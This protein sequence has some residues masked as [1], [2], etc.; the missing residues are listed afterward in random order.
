[1]RS[2]RNTKKERSMPE[3]KERHLGALYQAFSWWEQ[4]F[5]IKQ[6]S[7]NRQDA[8]KRGKTNIFS[9]E[10]EQLNLERFDVEG[11]IKHGVRQMVEEGPIAGAIWFWV[12]SIKGMGTGYLGARVLVLIDQPG[13]PRVSNLWS[14]AGIGVHNGKGVRGSGGKYNRK[15][16]TVL[17][18]EK[19]IAHQFILQR[20]SPYREEYDK[21]RGRLERTYDPTCNY[22][23]ALGYL[24]ELDNGRKSWR[25]TDGCPK[26]PNEY[27]IKWTPGHIGYMA[28][29]KISKLFLQHLW[30][31]WR[32]QL[33]LPLSE[34]YVFK[35]GSHAS[36][37]PPP[38]VDVFLAHF[39]GKLSADARKYL[40]LA[41]F[42]E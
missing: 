16:K 37:I 36:Y 6:R 26:V 27:L 19:Q 20:T 33:G 13:G 42:S 15:L 39:D 2:Q 30:V 5:L 21:Y 25:C 1:M 9:I 35:D 3:P 18:G 29:R 41:P 11:C 7:L 38:N 12:T 32:I 14:Y 17:M 23:G 28:K 10:T 34:P 22:C 4:Y 8:V 24:H 40:G 31:L